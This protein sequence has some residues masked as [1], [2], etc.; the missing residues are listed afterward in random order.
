[1]L[2][3]DLCRVDSSFRK[4]W[5]NR[6]LLIQMTR[7]NIESRYRGSVLGLLWSF[8]QPLMMLCIYTFVFSIVFQAKFGNIP[9]DN[10]MAF[11]VILF[12]GMMLYAVFS[13]SA[14]LSCSVIQNNP[15]YVKKVIFPL[16]ILP[17]TQIFCVVTLALPSLLLVLAGMAICGGPFTFSWTLILLP[18][19]I[20]PLLLLTSGIAFFVASLAV[21]IRDLSYVV[22]LVTQV[23]FFMTPIFYPITA[24]PEKFQIVLKLN[25]LSYIIEDCRAVLLYGNQP[26]WFHV[27]LSFLLG[28]I[29]YQLG[30][31]WF[32]KSK[33]GF[34]DVL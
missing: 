29:V 20:I 30:Y 9:N 5:S 26:D 12:S 1:M 32:V 23:L 25:P 18:I 7:R 21:Y 15:N 4:F 11:A 27:G 14:L 2:L 19:T 33:K 17:L 28:L 6:E 16:E 3:Y 22:G 34:A 31:V 24:V 10:R 13:E 8:I